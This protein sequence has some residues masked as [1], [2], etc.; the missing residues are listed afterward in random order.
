MTTAADYLDALRVALDV[1]SDNAVAAHIGVSRAAASRYR[2]GLTAP[3]DEV[4]ERIAHILK[5]HPGI[6]LLQMNAARTRNA[7][8]RRIWNDLARDFFKAVPPELDRRKTPRAPAPD[9]VL[10]RRETTAAQCSSPT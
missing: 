3:D 2:L 10:A 5:I 1:D 8:I 6:V 9:P 4:C 7:G